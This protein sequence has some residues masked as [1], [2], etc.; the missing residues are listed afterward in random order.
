MPLPLCYATGCLCVFRKHGRSRQFFGARSG[1]YFVQVLSVLLRYHRTVQ[2]LLLLSAA[3]K[4]LKTMIPLHISYIVSH[5]HQWSNHVRDIARDY[6]D[7]HSYLT[8][9]VGRQPCG[10]EA[11]PLERS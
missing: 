1:H 3:S 10:G 7:P 5:S 6:K 11:P 4:I 8:G 2:F 9:G